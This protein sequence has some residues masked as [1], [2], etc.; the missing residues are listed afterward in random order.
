[1]IFSNG[2]E[3]AFFIKKLDLSSLISDSRAERRFSKLA[4]G[5]CR[6]LLSTGLSTLTVN[7]HALSKD[8]GLEITR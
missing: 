4:S 3:T 2:I 1:L 7:L 5:K 8:F 6:Q